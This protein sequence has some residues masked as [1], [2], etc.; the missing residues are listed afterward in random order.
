[1]CISPLVEINRLDEAKQKHKELSQCLK[2]HLNELSMAWKL[3]ALSGGIV[4]RAT[5]LTK[6][7]YLFPK[8]HDCLEKRLCNVVRHPYLINL[9]LYDYPKHG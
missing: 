1:M 9:G 8:E 3:N 7:R 4:Y 5:K 2:S 6:V